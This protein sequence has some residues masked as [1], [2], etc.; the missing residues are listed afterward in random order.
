[1][2]DPKR[3]VLV[4]GN[5]QGGWLAQTLRADPAVAERFAIVYLSDYTERPADH[6]INEPDF[7]ASCA[8]VVWQTASTSKPPWFLSAVP[9]A[10]RQI[11]YPTLWLKL[12][13]P[14]YVVDPRNRPEPDFPWGRYPYGDRLVLKLL[15]QG[16]S[17]D[18]LPKRYV[19]TDLNTIVNL[20][21]FTEMSLAELRFNDRQSDIAVTP[22]IERTFRQRK[23]F[24]TVNHPT[25]AIL[26]RIYHGVASAL[27]DQP[28]PVYP[29]L[30]GN[31]AD[32]LGSVET[33]LHPQIIAH[34][35]LTWAR[36]AMR[37]R[38]FSAFLTLGEYLR[39]YAT[40][41]PIPP[42]EPP[43]LWLARGRQAAEH[44][45]LAEA[46]RILLEATC[47]YPAQSEFLHYLGLL[48]GRDG[49][50]VEAEKV[51]RYALS[52]HPR[53]ASLHCELGRLLLRQNFPDEAV[54]LFNE[55]LRLDPAHQ[56][57]RRQLVFLAGQPVV[58]ALNAG[59]AQRSVT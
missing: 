17:L 53:V 58:R 54:R 41:A 20:D 6:P 55:A 32:I 50:L 5:C 59:A 39:A 42:G 7:L 43:P 4:Y 46:Q 30:P 36:P 44:Q 12:L 57:A 1:M 45:D 8:A 22:Y 28:V 13:W 24:G 56:E 19:D 9:A 3:R 18:D 31:A 27:L 29:P 2:S 23:L 52:L 10:C 51:V 37:W 49:Q 14:T 25:F 16:V 11:R 15:E 34:F 21:R 40:F 35:H 48:L 33:P 26:N 47:R 38:Y